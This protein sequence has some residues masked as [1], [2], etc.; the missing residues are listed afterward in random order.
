M[1][2]EKGLGVIVGILG[3]PMARSNRRG[4]RLFRV[5]NVLPFLP[6]AGRA[7][8]YARLLFALA[9]VITGGLVLGNPASLL[10]DLVAAGKLGKKTGEGF[11]RW[12]SDGKR[13]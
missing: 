4:A 11:Y 13:V 8:S 6:L 2:R 3:A 9:M 5:L 7:P 10:R 1:V 12:S